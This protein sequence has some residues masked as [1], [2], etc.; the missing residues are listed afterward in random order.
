MKRILGWL[1]GAVLLLGS[2]ASAAPVYSNDFQ[3]TP[4]MTGWNYTFRTTDNA[5]E[6]VLGVFNHNQHVQLVLPGLAPGQYTVSFDFFIFNTWDAN[7]EHCCGPDYFTFQI[8]GTNFVHATFGGV[9]TCC[10]GVSISQGFT[11]ATPL[12][13]QAPLAPA[14]TD[15]SG[16][17]VLD[18]SSAFGTPVP[19]W[20][21]SLSFL[22]THA[23]GDL[24]LS[25]I[26]GV[27]QPGQ[28][29]NGYYDEPWALD[30][31]QVIATPVPEPST[32]LLL[33][34]GL[35]GLAGARQRRNG[36]R[37]PRG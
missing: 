5:G 16:V 30:N 35:A 32:L 19:N 33:G 3:G 18:I 14:G 9:P 37:P 20:R 36:Q 25:F 34:A 4:D 27:T 29:Y 17:G 6:T 12:G 23:G 28:W 11:L 15:A 26:G 10:G 22:F 21:Y 1:A 13:G 31:V 24:V 7:G 8:N 2:T